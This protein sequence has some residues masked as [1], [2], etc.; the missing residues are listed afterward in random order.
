MVRVLPVTVYVL[1]KKAA[2]LHRPLI[3]NEC[4]SWVKYPFHLL[5][6]PL[7]DYNILSRASV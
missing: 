5:S 7:G 1:S 6:L 2:P 4:V 3:D